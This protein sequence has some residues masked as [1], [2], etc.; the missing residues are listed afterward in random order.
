MPL[1]SN[2]RT[3]KRISADFDNGGVLHNDIRVENASDI[4][5]LGTGLKNEVGEYN[6]FLNVII[7]V[8]LIQSYLSDLIFFLVCSSLYSFPD[9]LPHLEHCFFFIFSVLM[10]Y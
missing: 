4:D 6:C 1:V 10:A 3:P 8:L 9:Y 7:Q 5:V 2:L